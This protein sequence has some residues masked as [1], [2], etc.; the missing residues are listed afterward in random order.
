MK[1][2]KLLNRT[3]EHKNIF[4]NADRLIA[5]HELEKKL[6]LD[7]DPKDNE[8]EHTGSN[9]LKHGKYVIIKLEDFY[10]GIR[11]SKLLQIKIK[12]INQIN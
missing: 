12:T 9:V 3:E 6:R 10:W 2:S 7:R 8:L 5:E 1:S 11:S 4:I